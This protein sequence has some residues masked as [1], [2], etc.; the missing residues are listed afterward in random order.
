MRIAI[1]TGS[2]SG[3][4]SGC[5]PVLVGHSD[6]EVALVIHALGH[7]KSRRRK[8]RRDLKKIMRIGPLG[9][10]VGLSMRSWFEAEPTDDLKTLASRHGIPFATTPRTN[11]NRT[12]D[13]L[14]EANVDLGL[15]LG[16]SIIFRKIFEVPR[17]GMLNMHGE[18]LPDFQ[19][20]ASVIWPIHE[21]VAET[22]FSIHRIDR[23]IDTG[24]LLYVE[25][26]PIE[27]RPTLRETVRHN[28]AETSRRVP[29]AMAQVVGNFESYLT[30]ARVQPS[31]RSFTTPTF[32]QFLKMRRQHERLRRE[33]AS[34]GS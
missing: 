32:R 13:L 6:I 10:L 15:S 1:L 26:R 9:A 20:A 14:R 31:A 33:A 28:V 29:G 18:I 25:R 8:L 5:L 27:F 16:N 30:K 19:G 24:P 17:Y 34:Q 12:R 7:Y 23:K 11:A 3:T 4:A 2:R 22:G 21:G